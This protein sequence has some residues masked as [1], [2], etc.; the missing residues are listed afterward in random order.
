MEN[1]EY[2]NHFNTED[3]HWWFIGQRKILTNGWLRTGD[4]EKANLEGYLYF[5]DCLKDMIVSGV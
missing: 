3:N 2:S 4:M 1:S 5:V